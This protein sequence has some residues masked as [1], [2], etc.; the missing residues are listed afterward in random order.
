MPPATDVTCRPLRK[1]SASAKKGSCPP[2]PFGSLRVDRP[3]HLLRAR[4][5]RA[6]LPCAFALSARS[7]GRAALARHSA[8]LLALLGARYAL[9]PGELS[10]R[11]DQRIWRVAR[12]RVLSVAI[13][14]R[15]LPHDH[16]PR[17]E[18][19]R[20]AFLRVVRAPCP[21]HRPLPA[22]RAA[23]DGLIRDICS[24]VLERCPP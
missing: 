5:W 16:L 18:R 7:L 20:G 10:L 6:S 3:R 8:E 24:F 23:A 11:R 21:W 13:R 2:G 14:R 22:D 15:A 9:P 17:R 4:A 19:E 1:M 12:R